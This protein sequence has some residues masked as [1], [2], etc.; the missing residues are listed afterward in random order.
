FFGVREF[1][2]AAA[3]NGINLHGGTRAFGSTFLVFTDYLRAAIRQ[4]A[5][6]HLPSIFIG[7]HDSIAVGEDG[8]THQPVEQLASFRAMPNLNVIRPADAN[9]TAAAWRVMAQTTDRPSLLVASRQSL[10]VLEETVDAPVERGG[11]VLA[12]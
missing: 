12:D 2:M 7:T 3:V 8:P 4:A 11:Y 6:M 9:E 1:G 10:P 5:L